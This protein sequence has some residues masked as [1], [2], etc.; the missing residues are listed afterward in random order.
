MEPLLVTLTDK[1]EV[2]PLFQHGGV[3]FLYALEGIVEYGF[4]AERYEL[5]PGDALQFDGGVAHGPTRLVKTPV[6][7]LSIIAHG[8]ADGG[9]SVH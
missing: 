3:E 9:R 4:G 1:S 2:F 7:F 8:N 6:R 5:H